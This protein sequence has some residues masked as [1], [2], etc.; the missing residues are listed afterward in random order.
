MVLRSAYL[1]LLDGFVWG[2]YVYIYQHA[3]AYHADLK[4]SC[5]QTFRL[6]TVAEAAVVLKFAVSPL[7]VI[8]VRVKLIMN[9]EGWLRDI[10]DS[11]LTLWKA[12]GF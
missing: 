1:Q 5:P 8:K 9:S 2:G 11:A 7:L 6:L 4:E 12:E 3:K 10:F